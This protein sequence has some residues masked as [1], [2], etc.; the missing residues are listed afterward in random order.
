MST[1]TAS[2][3]S[4]STL[5]EVIDALGVRDDLSDQRRQDLRSSLRYLRTTPDG[6][7]A[8]QRDYWDAAEELYEKL[9]LL[10]PALRWLHR[11]GWA[12]HGRHRSC[13]N[14]RPSG[15][16]MRLPVKAGRSARR[17]AG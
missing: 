16:R 10:G 11:R 15:D 6:R 5:H 3:V 17:A 1:K 9:P 7:I 4:P 14:P 12:N 13:R 8:L 2:R